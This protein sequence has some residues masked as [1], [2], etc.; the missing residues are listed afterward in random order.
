MDHSTKPIKAIAYRSQRAFLGL[1]LGIALAACSQGADKTS[2]ENG[3]VEGAKRTL[4][5]TQWLDE[6][7]ATELQFSPIELTFL[8]RKERNDEIDAFTYEAFA[9]QLAWKTA[10]VA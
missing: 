9:E 4:T 2:A 5:L 8:G 10:S 3:T 1:T 7:Y 6:Q